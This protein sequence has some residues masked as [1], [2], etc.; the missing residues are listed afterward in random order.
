[1]FDLIGSTI[2][3][4]RPQAVEEALVFLT[5]MIE[6]NQ[7]PQILIRDEGGY[8]LPILLDDDPRPL[9]GKLVNEA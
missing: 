6:V 8:W 4:W 5:F 1:M 9:P 3:K 2:G 7:S